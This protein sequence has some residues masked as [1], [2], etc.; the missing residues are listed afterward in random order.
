[1]FL[2]KGFLN[3]KLAK[4]EKRWGN[5]LITT[6]KILIS[7][8]IENTIFLNSVFLS[9]SLSPKIARLKTVD[10]PELNIR[11][12]KKKEEN[13]RRLNKLKPSVSN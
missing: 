7:Y 2:V 1:M 9:L 10:L 13:E 8:K 5:K 12:K 4:W 11:K 6:N 3:E